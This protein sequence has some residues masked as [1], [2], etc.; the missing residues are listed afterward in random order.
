MWGKTKTKKSVV[1]AGSHA[2]SFRLK[3]LVGA[4]EPSLQEILVK[5]PALLAFYKVSCPVCQLAFPYL[6]RLSASASLQIVGISQDDD[7]STTDFNQRFGV[8]FPTLLDQS[9]A[10]YP[11]SNAFAITSVPSLFLVETDG[12]ISKSFSGF[13]KRDFEALGQRAGVQIFR[14]EDNVP[15]WKPG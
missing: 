2:P 3:S 11:A 4:A 1:E 5:G 7:R 6:Q 8:T 15:E 10:G 12:G 13:S 9:S 14:P